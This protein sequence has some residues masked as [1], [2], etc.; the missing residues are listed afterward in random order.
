MNE[1]IWGFINHGPRVA[2]TKQ[3]EVNVFNEPVISNM[4][5]FRVSVSNFD[6]LQSSMFI[7]LNQSQA[8]EH[9]FC[10]F[11]ND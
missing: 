5:S 9:T 3:A 4:F 10:Q 1:V 8:S 2:S 6:E 7:I 11:Y